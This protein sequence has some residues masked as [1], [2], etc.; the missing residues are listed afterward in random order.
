MLATLLDTQFQ[1]IAIDRFD[2]YLNERVREL[3]AFQLVSEFEI[4]GNVYVCR[5]ELNGY[6]AAGFDIDESYSTPD[7]AA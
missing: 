6:T 1:L 7:L 2:S 3:I 5:N 4:N